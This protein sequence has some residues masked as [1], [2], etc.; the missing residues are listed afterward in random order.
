[1]ILGSSSF[2]MVHAWKEALS[3]AGRL[4]YACGKPCFDNQSA[5]ESELAANKIDVGGGPSRPTCIVV[6]HLP[7]LALLFHRDCF[8]CSRPGCDQN[9]T[10]SDRVDVRGREVYCVTSGACKAERMLCHSAA[11]PAGNTGSVVW[12]S[13]DDGGGGGGGRVC[14][15]D[16]RRRS[17]VSWTSTTGVYVDRLFIDWAQ[18][19][20][21][22]E[23]E[24]MAKRR[25]AEAEL[26]NSSTVIQPAQPAR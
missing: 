4:C 15:D 5:P 8:K 14:N 23:A 19:R 1:M 20:A 7:S 13:S 21:A 22:V 2:Q 16:E 26:R 25:A 9:L 18:T 17:V 3:L 10:A 11:P 12:G 6:S 24:R